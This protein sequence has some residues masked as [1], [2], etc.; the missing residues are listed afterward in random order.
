MSGPV[1]V[2]LGLPGSGKTTLARTLGEHL[3][4]P[5]LSLDSVKEALVEVLD[6]AV[7]AD[8]F[9][10]RRAARSVLVRL[11]GEQPRGCVVDIWVDP[12]R[13]DSDFVGAVGGL[14]V[15]EVVCRVPVEVALS[16]YAARD[17]HAAH[18]PADAE[19]DQRIREA[20]PAIG[21]LGLGPH[22][23]V[24]T[25][26]PVADEGLGRLLDWLREHGVAS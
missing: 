8:R 15:V 17:R 25:A 13:D 9:A 2:V 1:V 4:L 11:A 22:V 16:R 26:S 18:L 14:P 23:D 20:A 12:R 10:V 5:V 7:T 24:D 6:P 3:R 21:P 19:S